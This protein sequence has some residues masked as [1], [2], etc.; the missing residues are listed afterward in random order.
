MKSLILV[1]AYSSV[2]FASGRVVRTIIASDPVVCHIWT[3]PNNAAAGL[4][5]LNE[6]FGHASYREAG[7]EPRQL[8]LPNRWDGI[9]LL[10]SQG[11]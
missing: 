7:R 2:A 10:T 8:V 4:I 9:S 11:K 3:N 6:G 5:C 1:A